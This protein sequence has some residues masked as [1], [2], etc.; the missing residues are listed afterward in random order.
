MLVSEAAATAPCCCLGVELPE[1]SEE[2]AEFEVVVANEIRMMLMYASQHEVSNGV[3]AEDEPEVH[4]SRDEDALDR[5]SEEEKGRVVTRAASITCRS[6]VPMPVML[7][8]ILF[9][10]QLPALQPLFLH[11][12]DTFLEVQVESGKVESGSDESRDFPY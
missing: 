8:V 1:C 12:L 11:R 4:C 6:R 5:S 2:V 7:S 3:A 9:E 10:F